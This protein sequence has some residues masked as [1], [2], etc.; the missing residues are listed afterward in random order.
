MLGIHISEGTAEGW[1]GLGRKSA[2][3]SIATIAVLL[4]SI[5]TAVILITT[6]VG[7]RTNVNQPN[8]PVAPVAP[9]PTPAV[10]TPVQ[11]PSATTNEPTPSGVIEITAEKLVKEL[12]ANPNKYKEGTVF[13]VSGTLIKYGS[14][15]GKS[16]FL[17]PTVKPSSNTELG[18]EIILDPDK[19]G[20]RELSYKL[21]EL[22]NGDWV[23]VRGEFMHFNPNGFRGGALIENVLL[24]SVTPVK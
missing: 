17:G 21:N 20:A 13:Q 11:T 16:F 12:L 2:I 6:N 22:N 14:G 4:I 24:V 7:G 18:V 10:P 3:W 19:A 23:V 1:F 5:I 15:F 9:A 8:A